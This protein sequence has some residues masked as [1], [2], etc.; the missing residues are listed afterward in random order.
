MDEGFKPSG[1]IKIGPELITD[2]QVQQIRDAAGIIC[3]DHKRLAKKI[4]ELRDQLTG[5]VGPEDTHWDVGYR[6]ACDD[7]LRLLGME[8]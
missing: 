3:A 1:I 8:E 6:F 2:E 4:R 5:S 7:I